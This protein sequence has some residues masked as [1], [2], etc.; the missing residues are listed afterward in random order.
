M[1]LSRINK[2]R[3]LL[4]AFILATTIAIAI[5][6]ASIGLWQSV[7]LLATLVTASLAITLGAVKLASR[8][9][10]KSLQETAQLVRENGHQ[11]L[12]SPIAL[13]ILDLPTS[14]QEKL[15]KRLAQDYRVSDSQ[16]S[17]SLTALRSRRYQTPID[18]VRAAISALLLDDPQ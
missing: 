4:V 10:L 17:S 9:A 7:I 11:A 5:L 1:N 6:S 18:R 12:E 15:V 13:S 3:I 16:L 14:E 8:S 2:D